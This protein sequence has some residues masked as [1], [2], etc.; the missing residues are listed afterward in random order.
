MHRIAKQSLDRVL[1]QIVDGS[2]AGVIFLVPL[3]MGGRHAVGQ[4]VLTVL[5][6]AAGWTW[7][8]RECFLPNAAWRPARATPLILAG[9]A[10]VVLQVAP[11]PPSLLAWLAP[12]TAETLPLW[13]V[14]DATSTTHGSWP[15]VSFTPAETLGGLVLFLDFSLLFFVAAQRIE[16]VED[17]E[18]LLR[19]CALSAVC[20]A[21][22]GIVQLLTGNGKFL[23]CYSHPFASASGVAK[24]S[25]SNRN[26]FAHFLALGIGPLVWWLQDA[27]RRWRPPAISTFQSPTAGCRSAERETYLLCL[28]LGIVLFAGLLSLSRGGISVMFLAVGVSTVICYRASAVSGRLVVALAGIGLL[29]GT[30]LT[31]YGLDRVGSRLEELTSGSVERLDYQAGR[32][33]IWA[34]AAKAIPD[35][36]PLGAGV[37]SFAEVYPMHTDSIRNEDIEYTHA[38]NSFLQVTLETGVPGIALMLAGIVLTA[39]WCFRGAG[40]VV[41]TR[42]RVCAAAVAG[43]LSASVAHALVDFVWYVPACMAIMAILAACALRVSQLARN[44]QARKAEGGKRSRRWADRNDSVVR[45]PKSPSPKPSLAPLF[46]PAVVVLLTLLGGWMVKS[47]IGP[48]VAQLYWD[49]FLVAR[50]A[51][52]TQ[53]PMALADSKHQRRCIACL[54][55]VVH[56]QPTHA[57]A[58]LALAESH[59]RLF[60]ALQVNAENQMSVASIR[61]AAI[62]SRFPSHEALATW[63]SRAIGPHWTHLEQALD[64][65]RR[66]L[67]LSPLQGRGYVYLAQLSFLSGAD[68]SAGRACLQQAMRVRPFDGAVLGAV[69]SDALLAGDVARWLEYSRRAFHRGR[70]QQQQFV[71]DLVAGT[72]SEELPALIDFIIR[73]FNPDLHCLQFLHIACAERCPPERLFPLMRRQ[74][75]QARIEARKLGNREAAN[76]WLEA[77]RLYSQ[78]GNAAE[79]L[80][81]AQNALECDPGNYNVHYQLAL[82]LLGRR[83]FAEAE[84]HLRWC[85]QRAPSDRVVEARLREALK[86]RLD[87]ERRAAA[88]NQPLR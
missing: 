84:S 60:D 44:E 61:D 47:G 83:L 36:L 72:S 28:A 58:H 57:R 80:Q 20:M 16:R 78:L 1:L 5:A 74:A 8:V 87:G 66:A 53:S 26:H 9:L 11:L 32:R 59:R 13:S 69:A 18:R 82:G 86:G 71:G 22:F 31:V 12:H 68:A 70:W 33:T 75:E 67:R 30:L 42:F 76:V 3:L 85:L 43:S 73:E 17:V 45:N 77:Q 40:S 4:L 25:F 23:W 21:A 35:Y 79:A 54:E 52:Q 41:S 7:A 50:H 64:H 55:N 27:S 39:F 63:L 2:L 29:I 37:G 19:W 14:A 15:C 65:T 6:V 62:Q 46:W 51:A 38:E 48:A 24:G 88:E 81:C 49:E 56:W 10:V 34:A